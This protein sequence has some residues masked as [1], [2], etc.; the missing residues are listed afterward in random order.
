MSFKDELI[1]APLL[2]VTNYLFRSVYS[3]HFKSF[4]RAIIPFI[5]K[6]NFD[7]KTSILKRE[8]SSEINK[9]LPATAQILTNNPDDFIICAKNVY[10]L[11]GK[12]L[13]WNLGCPYPQVIKK[14]RGGGMLPYVDDIKNFLDKAIPSIPVKMSIKVR[15]GLDTSDTIYKLIEIF[16]DYPLE[17]L[18]I[19][20]RTVEQLYTGSVDLDVFSECLTLSKHEV[21]YN[22]DIYTVADYKRL[23]ERFPEIKKWMIGRGAVRNP[24]LAEKIKNESLDERLS[25]NDLIRIMNF[26]DDLVEAYKK[27]L[28]GDKH[29]LDKMKEVISY[30]YFSFDSNDKTLKKILRSQTLQEYLFSTRSLFKMDVD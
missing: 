6:G 17:E 24:L 14:R 29:L 30:L 7:K 13:N 25:E 3:T 21:V 27:I 11:R 4:D 16:N 9:N 26:H 8:L 2:G 19:H 18:I 23:K 1:L 5:T 12:V 28:S 10:S 22:G 15:L 20:P